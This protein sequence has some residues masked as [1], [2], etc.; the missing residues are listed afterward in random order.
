MSCH[1]S[2]SSSQ[3]QLLNGC[4]RRP[5]QHILDEILDLLNKE[6]DGDRVSSGYYCEEI[7]RAGRD[8]A[9]DGMSSNCSDDYKNDSCGWSYRIEDIQEVKSAQQ[10]VYILRFV[11][12]RR[13]RQRPSKN[14]LGKEAYSIIVGN[15]NDDELIDAIKLG[16]NRLILRIWKGGSR[17]WN[18]NRNENSSYLGTFVNCTIA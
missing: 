2:S 13:S 14:N 12:D 8:A 15:N 4:S 17:W 3:P 11:C 16:H 9:V 18:L 6:R 10:E 7:N 5:P 1:L